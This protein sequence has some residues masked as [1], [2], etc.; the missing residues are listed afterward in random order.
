MYSMQGLQESKQWSKLVHSLG[1]LLLE[2]FVHFCQAVM[3]GVLGR[4]SE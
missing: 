4:D 2:G 1:V 3:M